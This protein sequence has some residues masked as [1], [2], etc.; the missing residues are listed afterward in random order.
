MF[1]EA[2]DSISLSDYRCEIRVVIRTSNFM[3]QVEVTDFSI[4]PDWRITNL[5]QSALTKTPD[6]QGMLLCQLEL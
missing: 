6:S 5:A 4:K 1:G 2:I 3:M